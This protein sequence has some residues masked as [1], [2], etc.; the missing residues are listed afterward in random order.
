[1]HAVGFSV[2]FLVHGGG[3]WW[4]NDCMIGE[5]VVVDM[6]LL[7]RLS[8]VRDSLDTPY[9]LSLSERA[10]CICSCCCCYEST[11][12]IVE[13]LVMWIVREWKH[14]ACILKHIDSQVFFNLTHPD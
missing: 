1:M 6:A 7:V 12:K 3:K 2:E 13:F 8:C 10:D 9:M 14:M 5:A 4:V 11:S